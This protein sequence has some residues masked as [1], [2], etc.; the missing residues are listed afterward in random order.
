[1]AQEP[2]VLL[3]TARTPKL[4]LR[5][6]NIESGLANTCWRLCQEK[7]KGFQPDKENKLVDYLIRENTKGRKRRVC[8][9]RSGY[10]LSCS[11]NTK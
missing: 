1:M 3:S 11:T 2:L 6:A 4:H 5:R 10:V 7:C 8:D 9:W